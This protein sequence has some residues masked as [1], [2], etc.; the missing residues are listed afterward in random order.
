MELPVR[1]GVTQ[2]RDV[3][4]ARMLHMDKPVPGFRVDMEFAHRAIRDGVLVKPDY[5]VVLKGQAIAEALLF[6][7]QV[8]ASVEAM[9]VARRDLPRIECL[10][11][12]PWTSM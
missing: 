5:Q 11:V 2:F 3:S 6:R 9:R 1:L 7:G 12:A 8:P 4:A 10:G